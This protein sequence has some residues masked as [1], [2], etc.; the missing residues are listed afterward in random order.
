MF[1][2]GKSYSLWWSLAEDQRETKRFKWLQAIRFLLIVEVLWF[3]LF[4]CFFFWCGGG[5]VQNYRAWGKEKTSLKQLWAEV[6][7]F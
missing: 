2:K 1:C 7:E 4:V 5:G 3:F 6:M